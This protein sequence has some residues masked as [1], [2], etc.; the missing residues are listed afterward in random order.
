MHTAIGEIMARMSLGMADLDLG[1]SGKHWREKF[2]PERFLR[3]GI[4]QDRGSEGGADAAVYH[5]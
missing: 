5:K 4:K 1:E 2:A 3:S